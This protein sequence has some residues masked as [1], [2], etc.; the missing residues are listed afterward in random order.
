MYTYFLRS[1]IF[2]LVYSILFYTADFLNL[3]IDR[4]FRLGKRTDPS[5]PNASPRPLLVQFG[6]YG[7]KNLLMESLYKLKNVEQKFKG[8]NIAHDMTPKERNECKRL[9]SE[10][11]QK[12]AEDSSGEYIYRVR[13]YPGKMKIVPV[14]VRHDNVDTS[15]KR[16]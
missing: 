6:S 7:I 9:L 12:Q 4:V 14:K 13:G 1:I 8:V 15:V 2:Y 11:K 16:V 3:D 5:T 10:A